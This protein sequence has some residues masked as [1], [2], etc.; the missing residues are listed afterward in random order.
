MLVSY[1]R[2]F[3][4]LSR[5]LPCT[6]MIVAAV[7]LRCGP[8]SL[9]G[10]LMMFGGLLMHILRHWWFLFKVL[11]SEN[12]KSPGRG[13]RG[14]GSGQGLHLGTAT[15]SQLHAIPSTNC[16]WCFELG[17]PSSITLKC[18]ALPSRHSHSAAVEN[19]CSRKKRSISFGVA[20]WWVSDEAKKGR[21][22]PP[23]REASVPSRG[24]ASG[25]FPLRRLRLAPYR[26]RDPSESSAP[27]F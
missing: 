12:K 11:K 4:C 20:R 24:E 1:L 3:R 13:R 23:S 21:Q 27:S 7:L 18:G 5:L 14:D 8:M 17:A 26:N 22:Q 15:H 19:E 16:I 10:L 2:L 25:A 6:P 9:R